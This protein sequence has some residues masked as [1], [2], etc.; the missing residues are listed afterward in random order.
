MKCVAIVDELYGMIASFIVLIPKMESPTG[1]DK[2][3]SISLCSVVYKVCS[4]LLVKRLSSLLPRIISFKQGAFIHVRNIFEN[5]SLTQEMV[6]SINKPCRG[7]NVML[8]I[9]MAKAYDSVEWNFL[10]HVLSLFGFSLA[11]CHL[12]RQCVTTM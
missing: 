2:F 3:C 4:K 1:F 8:K 10:F 5:I 9:D 12:L 6:H 7:R 11:V